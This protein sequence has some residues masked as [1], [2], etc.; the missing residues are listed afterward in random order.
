[1]VEKKVNP[2]LSHV[3]QVKKENPKLGFKDVL[4]KAKTTYKKK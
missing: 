4:K 2:W 3:K 1:M